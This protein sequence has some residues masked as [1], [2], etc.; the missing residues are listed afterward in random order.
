MPGLIAE[1]NQAAYRATF[2]RTADFGSLDI[3]EI[4]KTL[5]NASELCESFNDSLECVKSIDEEIT[6][7][8]AEAITKIDA[9]LKLVEINK[10]S[11]A[12]TQA[13]GE[14]LQA[15]KDLLL[16]IKANELSKNFEEMSAELFLK[17]CGEN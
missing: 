10:L 17:G 13:F 2:R 4:A 16:E 6:E 15:A 11:P 12:F 1:L 3:S 8:S 7:K 5:N 14:V 9:A